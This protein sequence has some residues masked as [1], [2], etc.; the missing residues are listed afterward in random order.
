MQQKKYARNRIKMPK[1]S[2]KRPEKSKENEVLVTIT[3]EI[4]VSMRNVFKA[5]VSGQGKKIRDVLLKFIEDYV[6]N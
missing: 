6:K 1:E 4:P 2:P 5:K 3:F